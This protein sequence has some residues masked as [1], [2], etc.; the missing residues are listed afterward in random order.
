MRQFAAGGPAGSAADKTLLP[1]SA[2]QASDSAAAQQDGTAANQTAAAQHVAHR[3]ASAVAAF[4]KAEQPNCAGTA[5]N[6]G[7]QTRSADKHN[8]TAGMSTASDTLSRVQPKQAG[9]KSIA[10]KADDSRQGSHSTDSMPQATPATP[11]QNSPGN[12][13]LPLADRSQPTAVAAIREYAKGQVRTAFTSIKQMFAGSS[14]HSD[15]ENQEQQS[16]TDKT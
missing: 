7:R 12:A 2:H 9:T 14:N 4:N 15:Q 8:T 13:E 16:K 1:P 11:P 5:S 3:P 6:A 10:V